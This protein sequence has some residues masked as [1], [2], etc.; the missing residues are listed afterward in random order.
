MKCC[1]SEEERKSRVAAMTHDERL[2]CAKKN[3]YAAYG[4]IGSGLC[5]FGG[6]VGGLWNTM[7]AGSIG[8]ACGASFGLIFGA[9]GPLSCSNETLA[10]DIAFEA[11]AEAA[12]KQVEA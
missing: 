9:C 1:P 2:A 7:G 3:R 5:L 6:M 12:D 4:M 11:E 10:W 8:A